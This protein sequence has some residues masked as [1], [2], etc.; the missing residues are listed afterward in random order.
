MRVRGTDELVGGFNPKSWIPGGNSY[1][2]SEDS[3]LFAF[4]GPNIS[5]G[6]MDA[7]NVI[8]SRVEH[9]THA[10]YQSANNGLTFGG[11]DLEMYGEYF[12]EESKIYSNKYEYEKCIRK[13]GGKF[14]IDEYE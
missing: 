6:E 4:R 14:T 11:G 3:F 10:L 7:K 8:L 1:E 9:P 2:Y 5:R 12:N 13:V